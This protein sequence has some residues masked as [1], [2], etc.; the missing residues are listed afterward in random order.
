MSI[1][2]IDIISK[3]EELE[4]NLFD[5]IWIDIPI[6]LAEHSER[7][8]DLELRKWLGKNRSFV[9]ITPVRDAVYA[10]SFKEAGDINQLKTGKRISV[11]AWNICSKIKESDTWLRYY[12]DEIRK[13]K[14][15][16]PESIFHLL[17]DENALDSK[18]TK[19]GFEQRIQLI[20]EE[21][22]DVTSIRDF[23][24]HTKRKQVQP[25]DVLDAVILAIAASKSTDRTMLM[26]GDHQ[27]DSF[28]LPMHICLP[29][30]KRKQF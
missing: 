29:D 11:Q 24:N 8:C 30:L 3:I 13:W 16:H 12:P 25:D 17:N 20:Q 5:S 14:E 4:S 1:Q 7:E 27:T 15:S 28:G 2:Q 21:I 9:F 23:I 10:S 22:T 6:G 26:F 18:K 19:V